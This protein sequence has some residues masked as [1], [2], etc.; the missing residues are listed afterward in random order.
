KQAAVGVSWVLALISLIAGLYFPVELLPDGIRWMSEVQPFTP[1]TDL[2]RHV[3]V[4]TP[5]RD[6]VWVNLVKIVGFAVVTFPIGLW[7]VAQGVRIGRR[8]GTII[9]Y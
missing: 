4:G 9:E 1:A 3:L 8:R 5:I 6:P 7:A 2:V